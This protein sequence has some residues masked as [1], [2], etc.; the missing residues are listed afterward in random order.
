MRGYL[1]LYYTQLCVPIILNLGPLAIVNG[2]PWNHLTW[3]KKAI[4]VFFLQKNNWILQQPP[5]TIWMV[6]GFEKECFK[7]RMCVEFLDSSKM[8][9][10]FLWILT[11]CFD[12]KKCLLYVVLREIKTSSKSH[13]DRY[14]VVFLQNNPRKAPCR[15]IVKLV[16]WLTG[17]VLWKLSPQRKQL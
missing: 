14:R 4:K 6:G 17:G 16:P 2:C 8:E 3:N 11:I 7:I 9:P 5:K 15:G 10:F 1:L 12:T 13:S